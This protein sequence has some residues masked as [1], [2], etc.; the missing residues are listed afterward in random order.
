VLTRTHRS[1]SSAKSDELM[2]LKGVGEARA[3]AI[4]KGSPYARK[5]EL[6]Q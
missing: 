4:I 5:D 6:V 1:T 3:A 2:T